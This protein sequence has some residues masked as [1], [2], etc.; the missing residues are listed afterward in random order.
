MGYT[1]CGDFAD[2]FGRIQYFLDCR[3]AYSI[4]R[5]LDHFIAPADEVDETL[6][7][8]FYGVAGPNREFGKRQRR[9]LSRRWFE[10]FGSLFLV[11]PVAE[12]NQYPTMHQ[13]ARL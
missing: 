12:R 11:V 1:E 4:A 6:F 8:H 9:I 3:W 7:V 2:K 10:A 5:G 13:F